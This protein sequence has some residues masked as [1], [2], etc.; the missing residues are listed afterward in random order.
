[1]LSGCL[2]TV[3]IGVLEVLVMRVG[4]YLAMAAVTVLALMPM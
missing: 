2:T 4:W 3:L 1:M